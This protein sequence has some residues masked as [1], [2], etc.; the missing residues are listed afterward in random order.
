MSRHASE[1]DRRPG[2]MPPRVITGSAKGRRLFCPPDPRI[3]PATDRLKTALFN[4][5][6]DVDELAVLDLFAGCGAIGIEALSRGAAHATFVDSHRGAVEAIRA[7]LTACRLGERASVVEADAAGWTER[8]GHRGGLV[9]TP[10]DLVFVDPPYDLPVASLERIAT[11]LSTPGFLSPY[12]R[13]AFERRTGDDPPPLP[14]GCEMVLQ[15]AYGQTTLFV[16][17]H[18]PQP[19][20][21][22]EQM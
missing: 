13:L 11:A 8:A 3:R 1:R 17:E 19:G 16:A 14:E 5:L 21:I 10:F 22:Q 9:A 7:N 20:P 4:I 15:R 12:A 6:F 18:R 2:W